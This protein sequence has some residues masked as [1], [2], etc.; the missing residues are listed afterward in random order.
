M[1][2]GDQN[3]EKLV[4]A[5]MA[6]FQKNNSSKSSSQSATPDPAVTDFFTQCAEAVQK[7]GLVLQCFAENF[8]TPE[9][10]AEAVKQNGNALQYVPEKLRTPELCLVA[11]KQDANSIL[12][13]P[14]ELK[15][16]CNTQINLLKMH[17]N[18]SKPLLTRLRD[19][20]YKYI[21]PTRETYKEER[22]NLLKLINQ[23][24]SLENKDIV[25][26]IVQQSWINIKNIDGQLRTPEICDLALKQNGKALEYIPTDLKSMERCLIAYLKDNSS[27]KY[28]PKE[29]KNAIIK[30]ANLFLNTLNKI[31]NFQECSTFLQQYPRVS[32][33]VLSTQNLMNLIKVMAPEKNER[34]ISIPR[35]KEHHKEI[36]NNINTHLEKEQV[37]KNFKRS[38]TK[39]K[40]V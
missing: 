14:E 34:E 20:F 10:C 8:K 13:V 2:N 33:A 39:S 22:D 1:V 17:D 27:L 23:V 26:D 35:K 36:K 6:I 7:N 15:G 25:K 32:E 30:E 37:N 4:Q 29:Y 40:H 12:H 31:S 38:K 16:I 3:V 11:V 18:G 5:L 28:V 24:G 19:K 21:S 9:I